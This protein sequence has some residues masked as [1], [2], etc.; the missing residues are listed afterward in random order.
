M[1]TNYGVH[2][3]IEKAG[4]NKLDPGEWG[5]RVKCAYDSFEADGV[6]AA[7]TI[8]MCFVPKGARI[9]AGSMFHDALGT[10]VTLSVGDGTTA[11][12]YMAA[13]S[14]ASAGSLDF[15]AIDNLGEPLD[16]DKYMIVT[17][18]AAAATGTIKMFVW[19][20]LE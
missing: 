12:E 9:V 19:Y 8:S 10:G 3:T 2:R 17:V 11:D 16:D 20:V 5:G 6:T 14:A 18:G 4:L 7:S 15:D 13:A 1:S